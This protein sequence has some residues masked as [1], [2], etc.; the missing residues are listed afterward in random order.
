[1]VK[2]DKLVVLIVDDNLAF[3]NRI[4]RLLDDLDSINHIEVAN[5][6]EDAYR[7]FSTEKPDLVLLDINLKN[8]SGISFLAHI[9]QSGLLCKVIMIS[10]HADEQY[11]RECIEIGAD[12]FLDK[13]NEFSL[14]PGIIEELSPIL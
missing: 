4:I 3:V 1:M 2:A 12:Y 5:T 7:L 6:L 11:R 13:T 10:N 14:L 9:R 8:K